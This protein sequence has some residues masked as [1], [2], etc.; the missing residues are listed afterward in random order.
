MTNNHPEHETHT[1]KKYT[2]QDKQR[3]LIKP[4][5]TGYRCERKDRREASTLWRGLVDTQCLLNNELWTHFN[6]KS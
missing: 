6:G 5:T 3:A 2:R 1:T 4:Y